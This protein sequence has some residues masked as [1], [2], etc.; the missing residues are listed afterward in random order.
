[1]ETGRREERIPGT[2]PAKDPL[3]NNLAL[4]IDS[5]CEWLK[6]HFNCD[7]CPALGKCRCRWNGVSGK[8]LEKPLSKRDFQ[9]GYTRLLGALKSLRTNEVSPLPVIIPSTT[10]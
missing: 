9:E 2:S 8:C 7:Y 10:K 1:M 6:A 4:I 5:E 3:F